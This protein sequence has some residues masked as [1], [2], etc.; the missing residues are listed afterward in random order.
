MMKIKTGCVLVA[1]SVVLTAVVSTIVDVMPGEEGHMGNPTWPPHSLFHDAAMFCTLD[2]VM[3]IFMWL[4]LRKSKEPKVGFVAAAL[5]PFGFWLGFYYI[6]TLFPQAS[7]MATNVKDAAG[8]FIPLNSSNQA[9]WPANV[10]AMTPIVAGI[11][12]YMNAMIGTVMMLISAIGWFMYNRGVKA[13]E[14]DPKL[15]DN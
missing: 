9:L 13:G 11:P 15:I 7:L 4:L 6:T 1:I 10:K 8:N 14:R 5:F 3:L 2:A 12:L